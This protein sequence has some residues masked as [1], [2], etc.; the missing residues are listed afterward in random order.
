MV[1]ANLGLY[2][3]LGTIIVILGLLLVGL[4]GRGRLIR[5]PECDA[6]F[7]RPAFAEK[8]SGI[9]F[10]I[11]GLGSYTCPNC[12]YRASTNSFAYV[13]GNDSSSSSSNNKP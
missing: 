10:S 11:G 9:G 12:K 2:I 13:E 5:C 4:R 3:G 6:A 1:A 7:K 8:S